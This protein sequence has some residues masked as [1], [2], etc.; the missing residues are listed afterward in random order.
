MTEKILN[1]LWSPLCMILCAESCW[2]KKG[3][4][5]WSSKE[6][7]CYWV[8]LEYLKC[9]FSYRHFKA[10]GP[11]SK[12]LV[13]KYAYCYNECIT[14][15]WTIPYKSNI[16]TRVWTRVL[17]SPLTSFINSNTLNYSGNCETRVF[18]VFGYR[19]NRPWFHSFYSRQISNAVRSTSLLTTMQ[20]VVLSVP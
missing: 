19:P 16:C 14:A 10:T 6:S 7:F 9:A 17:S 20:S 8:C 15:T 13:P 3:C 1:K 2:R 12:I 4:E 18:R 5:V 11:K